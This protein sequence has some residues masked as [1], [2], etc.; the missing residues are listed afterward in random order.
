MCSESFSKRCRSCERARRTPREPSGSAVPLAATETLR[1]GCFVLSLSTLHPNPCPQFK[2]EGSRSETPSSLM[3][4]SFRK[5]SPEPFAHL[6]SGE[7]N[8][9]EHQWLTGEGVDRAPRT[10]LC[11]PHYQLALT[12][13]SQA[14]LESSKEI[15]DPDLR[16]RLYKNPSNQNTLCLTSLP[17]AT[18]RYG[19][20]FQRIS[21]EGLSSLQ[22]NNSGI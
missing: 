1:K 11:S 20:V 10:K 12:G 2:D 22:G 8:L 21:R 9:E 4:G 14:L 18:K 13:V 6:R 17:S 19:N 15:F 3:N 16:K 5:L 7:R